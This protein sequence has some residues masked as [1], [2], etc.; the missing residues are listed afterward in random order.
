MSYRLAFDLSGRF[1]AIASVGAPL[2]EQLYARPPPAS[3]VSVLLIHGTDDPLCPWCGGYVSFGSR[4]RGRVVSVEA[5]IDYWVAAEGCSTTP[6]TKDLP[7]ADPHD[8][9]RVHEEVYGGGREGTEVEL[10]AIEG[11]GHTWPGG[12]QYL[13]ERTIGI[14]CRDIDAS[15]VIWEFFKKHTSK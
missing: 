13:R 4:Y 1:A 14:T 8:G 2:S 11:G 9:T 15:Q 12:I 3:P 5:T 6:V 10:L 7:D